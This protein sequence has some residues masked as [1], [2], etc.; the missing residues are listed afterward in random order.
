MGLYKSYNIPKNALK[1][2]YEKYANFY[3]KSII[4]MPNGEFKLSND[5]TIPP[6]NIK[7]P[8]LTIPTP[9]IK[10]PD[11][12]IPKPNIKIPDL[13]IP[14]PNIKVPNLTIPTPNIKIPD[15]TIPTPNI[16]IPELRNITSIT[17][18][19]KIKNRS[20]KILNRTNHTRRLFH[21][22]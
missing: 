21:K 9:N 3:G 18:G 1:N 16:K 10:V 19:R 8:D 14:T 4:I 15:L 6:P 11:L 7:I 12:T 20:S 5:L 17:G 13:T 22:I 2:I